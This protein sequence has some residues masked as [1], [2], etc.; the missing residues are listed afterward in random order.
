LG[1]PSELRVGARFLGAPSELKVGAMFLGA[2]NELTINPRWWHLMTHCNICKLS[3]KK[4]T[5][6]KFRSPP[7]NISN[8]IY[9]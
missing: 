7:R 1:A 8:I 6:I 3:Q 4:F 5:N 9:A 2:P